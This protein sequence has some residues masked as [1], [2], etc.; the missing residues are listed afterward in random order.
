MPSM[1]V[2]TADT[3]SALRLQACHCEVMVV[4]RDRGVE[5]GGDHR[6]NLR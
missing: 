4:E 3:A 2:R 6:R 5:A 1:A